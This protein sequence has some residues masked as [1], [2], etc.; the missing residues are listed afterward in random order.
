MARQELVNIDVRELSNF[1]DELGQA[2]TEFKKELQKFMEG[3]GD[4]FLRILE[5]EIIRRN[6]MDSRL[7]LNSFHKGNDANI[8]SLS[9]GGMTLEV[10]TNVEYASY[11]NDGHWTNPKG[12]KTRWVPG[13]WQNDRFVY[14]PSAKTGMLLRQKWVEGKHYWD[15]AIRIIEKMIPSF[16]ESKLNDWITKYFI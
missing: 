16:M 3:I 8:W 11:V 2:G 7:L 6:A 12:V 1:F 9:D 5:D 14:D 15:S 10:G 13:Y 4:E